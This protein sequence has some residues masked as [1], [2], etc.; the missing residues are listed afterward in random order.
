MKERRRREK[1]GE[2]ERKTDLTLMEGIQ[3]GHF[4]TLYSFQFIIHPLCFTEYIH[5]VLMKDIVSNFVRMCFICLF[6]MLIAV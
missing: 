2:W 1:N 6:R 4:L 3:L 5:S